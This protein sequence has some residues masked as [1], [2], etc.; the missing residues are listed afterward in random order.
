MGYPDEYLINNSA[1]EDQFLF[2]LAEW[3]S[4]LTIA[5]HFGWKPLKE[6]YML[7]TDSNEV[8]IVKE[9]D[10]FN[11][12]YALMR[13]VKLLPDEEINN[14]IHSLDSFEYKNEKLEAIYYWSGKSKKDI[15][16]RFI[17]FCMTGEFNII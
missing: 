3:P 7:Y 14:P 13:A 12:A 17:Q 4:M 10:A 2:D 6:P 15:I 9:E 16:K 1:S 11:L 5:M 8:E